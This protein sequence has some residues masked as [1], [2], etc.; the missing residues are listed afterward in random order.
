[1]EHR[2][3]PLT[4]IKL[5]ESGDGPSE[6][7]LMRSGKYE[8]PWYGRFEITEKDF[9]EMIEGFNSKVRGIELSIDYHHRAEEIAAAWIKACRKKKA[10]KEFELWCEVDWT[11]KG[12]ETV[13]NKEL[14]YTSAEFDLGRAD[15]KTGQH[16]PAMLYGGALTNRPFIKN[17]APV[18]ELSETEWEE[19]NTMDLHEAQAKVTKLSEDIMNLTAENTSLT[20]KL[21]EVEDE[22]KRL[23]EENE[24]LKKDAET[25]KKEA[26]F[27]ELMGAGKLC[28]AQKEAYMSG[29]VDKLM[30]LAEKVNTTESGNGGTPTAESTDMTAEQAQD[31]VNKLAEEKVSASKGTMPI[32]RAIDI[33]LSENPKL[34]ALAQ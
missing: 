12:K 19:S 34:A 23:S 10:G 25:A 16:I 32:A 6:I 8:H 26:K 7:Q 29:D 14:I 30:E 9:D 33:V 24:K 11:P 31:E 27:N 13:T 15:S 22:A 20:T 21:S 4:Q 28:A 2:Y 17:M 5:A 18:M 1:M 3:A